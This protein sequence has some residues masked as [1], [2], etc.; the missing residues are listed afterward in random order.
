[1]ILKTIKAE[2]STNIPAKI[3]REKYI[4]TFVIF[5]TKPEGVTNFCQ[6]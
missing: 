1:M 5:L 6:L 3:I 4:H 2:Q